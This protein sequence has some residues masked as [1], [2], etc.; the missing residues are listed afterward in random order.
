MCIWPKE[1]GGGGELKMKGQ[2]G[3]LTVEM[4]YMDAELSRDTVYIY[5]YMH[6]RR[7]LGMVRLCTL[8]YYLPQSRI[9]LLSFPYGYMDSGV[10]C[11]LH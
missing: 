6:V 3:N 4:Q 9:L 5:E 2:V 7:W 11:C 1:G 10:K 8:T